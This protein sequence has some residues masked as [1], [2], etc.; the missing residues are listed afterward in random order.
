MDFEEKQLEELKMN[1]RR[2]ARQHNRELLPQKIADFV[3]E[4][5][6]PKAIMQEVIGEDIEYGKSMM[7]DKIIG[8]VVE[9]YGFT[10]A[11]MSIKSRKREIVHARQIAMYLLSTRTHLS[12][13]S[14]GEMF[15]NMDHTTVIHAR[16]SILYRMGNNTMIKKEIE[17]LNRQI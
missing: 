17:Y 6:A 16:D 9:Y 11:K 2:I 5:F 7:V 15:G 3:V 10:F 8:I 4:N 14:I 12:L 13:K 1:I